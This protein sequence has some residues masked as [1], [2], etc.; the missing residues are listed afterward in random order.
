MRSVQLRA[1]LVAFS[2]V[3]LLASTLTAADWPS[4]RGPNRDGISAEK[5]LLSEWSE[6]GPKLL[7]QVDKVL[8]RGFSSIVIAEGRI[9]AMGKVDG[10]CHLIALSKKDGKKLW[11]APVGGGEP[12]CTA[13][14][15][16]DRVYALGREGDFVCCDVDTGNVLWKKSFSK[17]F[18]GRMMSGWGYSE[19]PLID[20]D[21]LVCTPGSS[22]A[23][24]VAL[25]KKTGETIWKGPVPE[26]IGSRGRDGA[27]YSSVVI[28][29]ATGVKQ[30]V[31]L[32]GRG[33]F[34]FDAKTGAPLW[35]YNRIANGTANI[36]TPLIQDDHVFCSTGYG[37]GAALLKIR[38]S[39]AGLEADEVYFLNAKDMQ[40]HHGGMILYQD[41]VYCGHGHNNGFPLCITLET[42]EQAWSGGRGP[43]NGSAAIMM[44][45]GHLYFR[46][47]DGTMALI[48][49]T[50]EEY[51]LKGSFKLASV[52]GKS[53]PH[54]VISDGLLYLRD[55]DSLMVYNIR[56]K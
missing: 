3:A 6:E 17:D 54:P 55:Q 53:W 18:G 42:G 16:D 50:P 15:D 32:T 48:E 56:A 34:S 30:Y 31:Q 10:K 21:V 7:W 27:G 12:N 41:H 46:Y 25:N 19:S 24:V 44:A 1:C 4:W 45:D 47:E 13:T 35:S 2:G 38:K 40:N 39:D 26:E 51:R 52:K 9:F 20:G 8:G 36:S 49:A 28:S 37:T 23:L 11:S 5:G 43:G 14:V 22:D 33:I 29:N